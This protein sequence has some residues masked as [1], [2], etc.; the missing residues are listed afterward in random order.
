MRRNRGFMRLIQ[1]YLFRQLLGPT[2]FATG[3]LTVV[4][5]LSQSLSALDV[6][7]DQRQGLGVFIYITGLALPQL[8]SMILPI[9]LFVAAILSLNRLHTEQEIVVCFAAGVSRWQVIAPAIK[10]AAGAALL[11]LFLNLWIQ[12]QAGR[13]LRAE[14]MRARADLAASLVRPG[15]FIEPSPGLTVYAQEATPEGRLKNLFVHQQTG[16][17]STT[18]NA[19]DGQIEKIDGAS[20]LTMRRGSSQQLSKAGVLNFLAFNS[21]S[22]DLTPFLAITDVIRYKAQDRWLHELVFPDLDRQWERENTAKLLAEA[23]SR[24]ASSLYPL[25]LMAIALAAV[26]GGQFSRMGYGRRIIIAGAAAALVRIAGF[27]VLAA[28]VDTPWLNVLQYAVPVGAFAG[29][30][31]LMF[32]RVVAPR[33][34]RPRL[35]RTAIGAVA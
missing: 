23:H 16:A 9:A 24:V 20:V 1:G 26:L 7:V 19:R 11:C 21:Y 33:L 13:A 30:M 6:I 32:G 4:A 10:L 12:P 15:E 5:L 8:F 34:A 22:L 28:S 14:L 17:G 3:A 2:V 31:F 27:A 25:A 18:F 29:A 35:P